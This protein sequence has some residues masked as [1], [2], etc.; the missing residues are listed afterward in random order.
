[1]IG[2]GKI[3]LRDSALPAKS[4]GIKSSSDTNRERWMGRRGGNDPDG[5]IL[6]VVGYRGS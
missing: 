5:S 4:I 1:M 2:S 3:G 6:D